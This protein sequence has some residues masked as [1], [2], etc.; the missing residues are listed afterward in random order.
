VPEKKR[1]NIIID[2]RYP[3]EVHRVE[4]LNREKRKKIINGK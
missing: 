1:K 2:L 4:T 3:F